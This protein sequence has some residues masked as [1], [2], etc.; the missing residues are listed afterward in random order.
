MPIGLD[1]WWD[2]PN[3]KAAQVSFT[4]KGTFILDKLR[5]H[6]AAKL[7]DILADV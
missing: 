4:A 3:Y 2:E 5:A 6:D 1:P 7:K